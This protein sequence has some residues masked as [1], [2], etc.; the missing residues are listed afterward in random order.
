MSLLA[1]EIDE[2]LPRRIVVALDLPE[3]PAPMY[4]VRAGFH[5]LKLGFGRL[6]GRRFG[7]DRGNG[8]GIHD[9]VCEDLNGRVERTM[10]SLVKLSVKMGGINN[11]RG[12]F[13]L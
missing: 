7:N 9:C 6:E 1:L 11:S 10:A 8:F 5:R 12:P 2:Q 3:T 4:H 13:Y